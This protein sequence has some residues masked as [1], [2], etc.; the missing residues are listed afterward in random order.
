MFVNCIANITCLDQKS[1][2]M[3]WIF[4]FNASGDY[5]FGFTPVCSE[6]RVLFTSDKTYCLNAS[7]GSEIWKFSQP[8]GKFAVDGS[9]AI[10]DGK[11][12]VSDWDGHHYYCLDEYTGKELWNITVE[13]NAQSTPAID[14]GKAVLGS[15]DWG[16]GGKIYCVDLGNGREI[17]NLSP[18]NSP[19][20]SAAI[21]GGAVYM[22]TYNFGGD[23]D[24]LAIS[25]D[26][27][28]ILWKARISPTDATPVVV[29]NKVYLCSGCEGFSELATYCFDANSGDLMWNTSP[30]EDIGDWRCSPAYADGLLFAGRAKFTEYAGTFALNATTGDVVWSY[31]EGGSSPSL[32]GG[33]L[34][35]VGGGRVYA[36]G[37]DLSITE[38]E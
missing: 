2:K 3:L 8:T 26:N 13:G 31:P 34:F 28:S 17:W 35:T 4:P 32:A 38:E 10:A 37:D 20:G 21:Y 29:N 22:A 9:P 1:G 15:W 23:G 24:I 30:D 11:V 19:C 27:G 16:M 18:D 33:M 25:L 14:Q 12:V 7:D 36:F 5:A 6:G